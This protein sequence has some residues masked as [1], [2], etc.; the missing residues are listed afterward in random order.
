MGILLYEIENASFNARWFKNENGTEYFVTDDV[1]GASSDTDYKI[2]TCIRAL[3]G[4]GRLQ[5]RISSKAYAIL[6]A[7][8]MPLSIK[9]AHYMVLF[10]IK[11][12]IKH[13]VKFFATIYNKYFEKVIWSR[14]GKANGYLTELGEA[15]L[16][17]LDVVSNTMK[18][19]CYNPPIEH[20]ESL[21]RGSTGIYRADDKMEI[22]SHYES[23]KRNTKAGYSFCSICSEPSCLLN[24]AM[25]IIFATTAE[26]IQKANSFDEK[27]K[28][29]LTLMDFFTTDEVEHFLRN[30][31][32]QGYPV[33]NEVTP[34]WLQTKYTW[35]RKMTE[36]IDLREASIRYDIKGKDIYRQDVWNGRYSGKMFE[37]IPENQ[38]RF[39][40]DF[41]ELLDSAF[42][43]VDDS[44]IEIEMNETVA[45]SLSEEKI[46]SKS[47]SDTDGEVLLDSKWD[48][49]SE[50]NIRD[51][52]WR[53]DAKEFYSRLIESTKQFNDRY[54]GMLNLEKNENTSG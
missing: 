40:P 15:V 1:L 53:R 17:F 39:P 7:V 47:S 38:E 32:V 42:G 45:P 37:I 11:N 54:K 21:R 48:K 52:T 6:V 3:T 28:I 23:S 46:V 34:L 2:G 18:P 51:P 50:K 5:G 27:R 14:E 49:W 24:K 33:S 36:H 30:F 9:R 20:K 13:K 44:I 12:V 10:D 19:Y 16:K 26:L 4:G 43:A 22:A 29:K 25:C 35:P 41:D 8:M 31:T